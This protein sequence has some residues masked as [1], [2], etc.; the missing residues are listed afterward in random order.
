MFV[1]SGQDYLIIDA[2]NRKSYS[3]SD[4]ELIRT[5]IE[6]HLELRPFGLSIS[7]RKVLRIMGR[8]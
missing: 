3:W 6:L 8:R 1:A 5:Q 2:I 4:P 7:D